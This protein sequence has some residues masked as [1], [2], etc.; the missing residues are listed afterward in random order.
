MCV[1]SVAKEKQGVLNST[2]EGKRGGW[3]KKREKTTLR[4]NRGTEKSEGKAETEKRED[5][6]M[7]ARE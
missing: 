6:G 7:R 3:G 2:K 1:N 5:E 4:E